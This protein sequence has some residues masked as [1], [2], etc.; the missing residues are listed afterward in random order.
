[1]NI[2][3]FQII[4]KFYFNVIIIFYLT[5]AGPDVRVI[6]HKTANSAGVFVADYIT[7]STELH[8]VLCETGT[9]VLR[10]FFKFGEI[11]IKN[12]TVEIICC[13]QTIECNKIVNKD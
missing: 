4:L 13:I 11:T 8:P 6:L 10:F 2:I 5:A 7:T 12:R 1:M 3:F 9:R